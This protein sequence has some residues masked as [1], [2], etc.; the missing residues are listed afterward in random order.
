[1]CEIQ[2]QQLNRCN[3]LFTLDILT[4]H[5]SVGQFGTYAIN[6]FHTDQ[7]WF[8]QWTGRTTASNTNKHQIE[9][10]K[11]CSKRKTSIWISIRRTI[12]ISFSQLVYDKTSFPVGEDCW[13]ISSNV[14]I[15]SNHSLM[16]DQK[17]FFD[18]SRFFFTVWE[19]LSIR[20][21]AD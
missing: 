10:L 13:S 6:L 8:V 9:W 4:V 16:I 1:M 11:Q 7:T 2:Q 17:I 3:S 12:K 18:F 21:K 5:I 15:S 20:R 14:S 19:N